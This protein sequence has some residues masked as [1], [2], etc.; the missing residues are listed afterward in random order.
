MKPEPISG[1]YQE[2]SL[3]LRPNQSLKKKL[4]LS[5]NGKR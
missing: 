3:R 4:N 2:H 1:N 5:L